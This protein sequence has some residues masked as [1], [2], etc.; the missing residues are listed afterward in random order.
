MDLVGMVS[1]GENNNTLLIPGEAT[2]LSTGVGTTKIEIWK[3][4]VAGSSYGII[5][6]REFST[7]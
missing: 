2:I 3:L 7:H 5:V 1:T 6:S 4:S